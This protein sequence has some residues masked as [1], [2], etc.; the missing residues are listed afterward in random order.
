MVEK[1]QRKG[2][3]PTLVRRCIGAV[4]MEKQWRTLKTKDGAAI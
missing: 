3:P 2:K 4:T 1:V